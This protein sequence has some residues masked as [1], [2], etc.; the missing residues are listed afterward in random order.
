MLLSIITGYFILF[1]TFGNVIVVS[2][3]NSEEMFI[4]TKVFQ[5]GSNEAAGLNEILVAAQ[6]LSYYHNCDE[7]MASKSMLNFWFFSEFFREAATVGC[8]CKPTYF[9]RSESCLW[10]SRVISTL[11]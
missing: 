6:I 10:G 2:L 11:Y 4:S 5:K 8:N 3:T 7:S 9:R 1:F